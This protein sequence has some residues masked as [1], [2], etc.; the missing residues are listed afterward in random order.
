VKIA[1]VYKTN[2]SNGQYLMILSS[3]TKYDVSVE[4]DGYAEQQGSFTVPDKKGEF[5]LKQ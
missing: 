5:E 3:G 2:P 4:S 1:G